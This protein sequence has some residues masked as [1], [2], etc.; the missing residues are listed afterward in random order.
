MTRRSV[1]G[2]STNKTLL[3]SCSVQINYQ[4]NLPKQKH[5]YHFILMF[6]PTLLA[7]LPLRPVV[8]QITP[9][10]YSDYTLKGMQTAS[11]M[12]MVSIQFRVVV[13]PLDLRQL[14]SN[15]KLL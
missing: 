8:L 11:F 14:S 13:C 4:M 7:T 5:L 15:L 9:P 3:I 1:F 12:V 2:A 6:P 10:K